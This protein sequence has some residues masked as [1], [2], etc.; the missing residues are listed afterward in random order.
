MAIV[1]ADIIDRCL[2]EK[3]TTLSR[4]SDYLKVVSRVADW[5]PDG[6]FGAFS[7]IKGAEELAKKLREA[8]ARSEDYDDAVSAFATQT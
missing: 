5:S 1:G 6:E 3:D 4:M 7:G 8:L 2:I